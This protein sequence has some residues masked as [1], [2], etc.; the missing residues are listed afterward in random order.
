MGS[1]PT[2]KAWQKLQGKPA[3]SALF[4]AAMMARVPYFASVMPRVQKM[5]PGYCEVTAPKWIGVYNHIGTFHAIAACNLA[6]VSMGMLMEATVPSSHRWIPKAMNVQY[7]GKATT[8]LRAVATLDI[9]D[10]DAITE[11]TDVVVPV[12][13]TDRNGDE[14]V[15]AE[16]TTWVT[17][18]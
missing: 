12:S 13:I 7:L 9:P 1:S 14:V 10:F 11:G 15:S 4:S 5:A 3:G 16:I 17:P 6:E 8:S 2:Y 18:A